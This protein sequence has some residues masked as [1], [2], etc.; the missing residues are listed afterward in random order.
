MVDVSS[1]SWGFVSWEC[2]GREGVGEGWLTLA[3][4]AMH[5]LASMPSLV[6]VVIMQNFARSTN[7]TRSSTFSLREGS[8]RFFAT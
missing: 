6:L 2:E 8:C 5:L 7:S 1:W 3:A 4:M